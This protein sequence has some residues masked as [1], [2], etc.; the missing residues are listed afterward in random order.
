[1]ATAVKKFTNGGGFKPTTKNEKEIL[2]NKLVQIFQKDIIE[3]VF[4]KTKT[5][6]VSY[7]DLKNYQAIQKLRAILHTIQFLKNKKTTLEE[8]QTK[9]L[10]SVGKNLNSVTLDIVIDIYTR[11]MHS[12]SGEY[13]IKLIAHQNKDEQKTFLVNKCN[14]ENQCINKDIKINDDINLIIQTSKKTNYNLFDTILNYYR[15]SGKTSSLVEVVSSRDYDDMVILYKITN[16]IMFKINNKYFKIDFNKLNNS[17]DL[18]KLEQGVSTEDNITP[19][20][21]NNSGL[22]LAFVAP[23]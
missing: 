16:M 12:H 13:I 17:N 5:L 7:K 1:M 15:C 10:E 14:P 21:Y 3:S 9:I 8:H 4:Q 18:Y 2:Q 11:V 23:L 22:Q 6:Y 19:G 20:D